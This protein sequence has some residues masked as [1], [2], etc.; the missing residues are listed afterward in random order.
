MLNYIFILCNCTWRL[1]F[2]GRGGEA[3]I[4]TYKYHRNIKIKYYVREEWEHRGDLSYNVRHTKVADLCT[5]LACTKI[6]HFLVVL[7]HSLHFWGGKWAG[8]SKGAWPLAIQHIN[9]N[10]H[11]K[12]EEIMADIYSSSFCV[13]TFN[14]VP[15]L[16]TRP[17][18]LIWHILLQ[19]A[20]HQDWRMWQFSLFWVHFGSVAFFSSTL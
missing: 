10:L 18:P 15:K 8:L 12:L 19:L 2:I 5:R 9:Y 14:D 16:L 13:R 11:Q 4:I 20:F 7:C 6:C 1:R 3:A 17:A